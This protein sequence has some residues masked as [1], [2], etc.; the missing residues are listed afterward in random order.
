MGGTLPHWNPWKAQGM[1]SHLKVICVKNCMATRME[2]NKGGRMAFLCIVFQITSVF[3]DVTPIGKA[4][5]CL[6]DHAIK[7]KCMLKPTHLQ[8]SIFG[9]ERTLSCQWPSLMAGCGLFC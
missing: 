4:K 3:R 9:A 1:R 2:A 5:A 8:C 7:L 6:K